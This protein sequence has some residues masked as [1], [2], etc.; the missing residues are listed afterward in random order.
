MPSTNCSSIAIYRI[1]WQYSLNFAI[2][3]SV[4]SDL[5][6]ESAC[7]I[8]KI[9]TKFSIHHKGHSYITDQMKTRGQM[10]SARKSAASTKI[11]YFRKTVSKKKIL[12]R[13]PQKVCLHITLWSMSFHLDQLTVGLS[14]CCSFSIP[15]FWA[16]MKWEVIAENAVTPLVE[17]LLKFEGCQFCISR[18]FKLKIS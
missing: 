16:C 18:C 17:E 11:C 1:V 8:L 4:I 3:P 2:N 12:H 15:R 13:Q 9:L 6:H 7:L 5:K 10:K 14:S